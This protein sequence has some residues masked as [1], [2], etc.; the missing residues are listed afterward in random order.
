MDTLDPSDRRAAETALRWIRKPGADGQGG[1]LN[2]CY[3]AVDRHV[4]AGRSEEAALEAGAPGGAGAATYAGLLEEMAALAGALRML[5]AAP[6][7][8]VPVLMPAGRDQVL[9]LLACWRLGA[10][11]HLLP[12]DLGA[13]D[14]A[15]GIE[16]IAPPVLLAA[17]ES[18]WR[19][20]LETAA[21]E[22]GS[23]V[24]RQPGD[25]SHH[26]R[27]SEPRDL[28]WDFVVKA[29]RSDPAPCARVAA[30]E[31]AYAELDRSGGEPGELR[32]DVTAT[33]PLALAAA[34]YASE[35]ESSRQGSSADRPALAVLAPMVAGRPLRLG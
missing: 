22:V 34:A 25:A 23:V 32:W 27:L 2:L 35:P 15:A 19:E 10:V 28:E 9:A 26:A 14:V 20:A 29:G 17:G 3:N 31:P 5:G 13:A 33:G 11:P 1:V 4:I 8:P 16:A 21:V 18:A 30:Q 6:S 7:V 12:A 24:V